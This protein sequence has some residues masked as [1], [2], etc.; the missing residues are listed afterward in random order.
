[1]GEKK[2]KTFQ[3]E[4]LCQRRQRKS[5]REENKMIFL[6]KKNLRKN[7]QRKIGQVNKHHIMK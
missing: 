6:I 5:E 7:K 2:K 1:M 3:G 4:K